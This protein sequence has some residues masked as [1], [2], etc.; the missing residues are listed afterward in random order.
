VPFSSLPL[1]TLSLIYCTDK[2]AQDPIRDKMSGRGL[3]YPDTYAEFRLMFLPPAASALLVVFSR[4]HNVRSSSDQSR[5]LC[6]NLAQYIAE[7]LLKINERGRWSDP[8]PPEGPSRVKQ[9][10][11]IFQ[12]A[13]LIKWVDVFTLPAF[14]SCL[15]SIP[16]PAIS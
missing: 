1:P 12:T 14:G 5:D 3:L 10:E 4:N 9:D 7:R 8:P 16:A 15:A 13:R 2:E 6:L 11:E